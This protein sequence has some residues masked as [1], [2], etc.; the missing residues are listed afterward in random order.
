MLQTIS[1]FVGAVGLAALFVLALERAA[2]RIGL[3]DAPAGRKTHAAPTPVVGGLAIFLAFVVVSAVLG[4]GPGRFAGFEI[5]LAVVLLIGLVDDAFDLRPRAKLLALLFAAVLMTTPGLVLAS[6]L[7]VIGDVEISLGVLAAPVTILMVA[8]LA[9]AW[10][11]L[12]GVDGA[13]GGAAAVALAALAVAA[14]T[15]GRG[16]L[17][18]MIVP[19]LGATLGFLAFNL[20]HRWRARARVFLGDAGSLMLGAG[21]AWL[22]AA[23]AT[24]DR[25]AGSEALPL[26]ALL[27][28]V[29]VP[30]FD[31]LGL[32]ARRIASGRSPMAA[33]REHLHHLLMEAGLSPAKAAAVVI[34]ACA[35]CGAVGVGGVALG[36][37]DL[38][39]G[40][41][42]AVPFA[43]HAAF[44]TSVTRSRTVAAS[45]GRAPGARRLAPRPGLPARTDIPAGPER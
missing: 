11:M 38:V 1:G 5:G 4:L 18:L 32:M 16:D 29:C 33:D 17:A 35:A 13:A 15:A 6:H 2:P 14:V 45:P 12:D 42:L 3:M 27:W 26:V 25:A 9:N 36:V 39:L 37:P 43:L 7:G 44:V 20:R 31:T 23:L 41:G 28:I 10:N 40:L 30:A 24:P 8:G 21:I 19:L 22:I 34:G